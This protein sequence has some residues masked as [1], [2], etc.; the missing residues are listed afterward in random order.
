MPGQ[1]HFKLDEALL[2]PVGG[3]SLLVPPSREVRAG[4]AP[5]ELRGI[6]CLAQRHF[7]RVVAAEMG[8]EGRVEGGGRV[9]GP[10]PDPLLEGQSASLTAPPSL[11]S[12]GLHNH[13]A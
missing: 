5:L 9:R 7:G 8:A 1:G 2:I 11:L 10:E 3:D 13:P 12:S 6:Q 4:S